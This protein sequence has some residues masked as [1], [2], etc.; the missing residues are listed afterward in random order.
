MTSSRFQKGHSGNPKGRPKAKP[1]ERVSAFD[2]VI[3]RTLTVVQGGQE[4]ELTVE[5]ALQL[6]T[7]QDAIGGSRLAQREILKM[8][9]KREQAMS[10]RQPVRS[11]VTL[12][13]QTDDP[14]NADQAMVLLGIANADNDPVPG[15][16]LQ[17]WAVQAA[18]TRRGRRALWVK[19]LAEVRR[20]V[21]NPEEIKWPRGSAGWVKVD[22]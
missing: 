20:C 4:R 8:I 6:K 1:E 21:Q 5:E 9:R 13:A 2:I 12:R 22:E 3:D 19:E 7:Y 11:G 18:L 15:L 14:R 10:A 17:G 16:K